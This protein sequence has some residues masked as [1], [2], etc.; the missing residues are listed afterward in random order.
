[1]KAMDFFTI[2]IDAAMVGKIYNLACN[3]MSEP[4]NDSAENIAVNLLDKALDA[5]LEV[6]DGNGDVADLGRTDVKLTLVH[7][8]PKPEKRAVKT[9]KGGP[10][11]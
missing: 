6:W 7:P 5:A 3:S 4:D 9:R 1:M 10:R 2:A 11:Q 8:M